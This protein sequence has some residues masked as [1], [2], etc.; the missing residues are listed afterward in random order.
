MGLKTSS[1]IRIWISFLSGI[2]AHC[3]FGYTHISL[4]TGEISC[5]QRW[6]ASFFL[7]SRVPQAFFSFCVCDCV[8][9]DEEYWDCQQRLRCTRCFNLQ[10]S[11]ENTLP[12]FCLL[13]TWTHTHAYTSVTLVPVSLVNLP[14]VCFSHELSFITSRLLN[15]PL[16][17]PCPLPPPLSSFST[18]HFLSYFFVI[19]SFL[20]LPFLIS[21]YF[22]S[23]PTLISYPFYFL[24]IFFPL[25]FSSS[26]SFHLISFPYHNPHIYFYFISTSSSS[27]FFLFFFIYFALPLQF[28][29]CLL[30]PIPVLYFSILSIFLIQFSIFFFASLNHSTPSPYFFHLL[31]SFYSFHVLNFSSYSVLFLSLILASFLF[32]S[33]PYLFFCLSFFP[34][35]SLS[36]SCL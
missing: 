28:L 17:F 29:F 33:C 12:H 3:F 14:S 19:F 20:S 4:A 36:S 25:L 13:V 23:L 26:F 8:K 27:S 1:K 16:P 11:S 21:C 34:F 6:Q 24:Y 7:L 31:S 35:V 10:I 2:W 30:L 15:W 22:L 5:G 32:L 18:L 9:S